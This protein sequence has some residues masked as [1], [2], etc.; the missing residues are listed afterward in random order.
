MVCT[1]LEHRF[2][3]LGV[4]RGQRALLSAIR[5]MFVGLGGYGSLLALGFAMHGS[6]EEIKESRSQTDAEGMPRYPRNY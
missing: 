5:S 1:F 6:A 2:F 4:R 3:V